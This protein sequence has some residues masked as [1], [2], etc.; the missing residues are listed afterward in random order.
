MLLTII[1][2]VYNERKNL[3]SNFMKIYKEAGALGNLEIILAEDGSTDGTREIARRF[4]KMNGV[5]LLSSEK[6]LGKGGAIREAAKVAHGDVIGYMDID[7][8]VPPRY[9][10]SA[11]MH[12]EEG[13]KVVIGSRYVSGSQT[14][15]Y[16]SRLILS[17][18][19]NAMLFLFFGSRV[20]DHQCGF[21]FFDG[22]YFKQKMKQSHDSK[23]FFDSE[24]LIL[25]QRD[26]IRPYELPVQWKEQKT[27]TFR[28]SD[29]LLFVKAMLK[30]RFGSHGRSLAL[31]SAGSNANP[32]D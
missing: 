4:S 24:L 28:Y 22:K 27:S 9:I 6:R 1:L 21:K 30:L 14:S 20:R 8:A 13:N 19:Y 31:H 23:W 29:I 15:R 3:E 11:V 25:A 16:L 26:G 2:P 7:L 32:Q 12:V 18:S 5:I 17:L 10:K